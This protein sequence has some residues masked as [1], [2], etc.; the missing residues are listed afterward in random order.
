M[1]EVN[2]YN[3][4]KQ[5]VNPLEASYSASLSNAP[6]DELHKWLM[7]QRGYFKN[8]QNGK[9]EAKRKDPI[10]N[11]PIETFNQ[12]L[13]D[14]LH[15]FLSSILSKSNSMANLK[16]SEIKKILWSMSDDLALVLFEC[17]PNGLTQITRQN[18]FCT[19]QTKIECE[20]SKTKEGKFAKLLF[21]DNVKETMTHTDNMDIS[22]NPAGLK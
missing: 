3:L 12:R 10:T 18:L 6:E 4:P 11:L 21:G 7:E 5:S 16:E 8:M 22:S 14:E 2:T 13:Y 17:K 20:M 1:V 19:I 15:R 9:W